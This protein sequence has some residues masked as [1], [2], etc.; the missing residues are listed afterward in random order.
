MTTRV[1]LLREI[2]DDYAAALSLDSWSLTTE[3][4]RDIIRDLD[5]IDPLRAAVR[6]I[7][8]A[9]EDPGSHPDYHRMVAIRTK[10][11]WPSLWRAIQQAIKE[12]K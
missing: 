11:D 2:L 5:D 12:I 10:H 1:I 6:G 4:L 3:Q 7:H 9:V 8:R